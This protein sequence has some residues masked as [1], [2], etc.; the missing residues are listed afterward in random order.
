MSRKKLKRFRGKLQHETL[1]LRI[2]MYLS[3]I[4]EMGDLCLKKFEFLNVAKFPTLARLIIRYS[5]RELLQNVNLF[6]LRKRFS[7]FEISSKKIFL[8]RI[9]SSLAFGIEG[10]SIF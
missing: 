7:S 5:I 10:L 3:F 8:I 9:F 6:T 2:Y 4:N 1:S